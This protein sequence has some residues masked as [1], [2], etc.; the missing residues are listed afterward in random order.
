LAYQP[1]GNG[2]EMMF[3]TMDDEFGMFEATHFPG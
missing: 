1:V 3:L 2:R